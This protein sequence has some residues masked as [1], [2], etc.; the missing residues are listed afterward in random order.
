[1]RL[2]G[3]GIIGIGWKMRELEILVYDRVKRGY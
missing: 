3:L 2:I 1:M